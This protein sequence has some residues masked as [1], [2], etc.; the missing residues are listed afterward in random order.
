[1]ETIDII[2]QLCQKKGISVAQLEG[3]LGYGNGSIGKSK[4]MMADRMYQIAQYFG[5]S[6]EYLMTGK[7]IQE[8][9]DEMALLRQQ[10]SILMEINQISQKMSDAYKA[11]DQYKDTISSLKQEYIKIEKK[12]EYQKSEEKEENY[13]DWMIFNPEDLPF[14]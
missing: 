5:V 7:T 3:D 4:G 8:A 10:Q 1:M 6:M 13:N 11:I 14:K 9:D 2:K 12:K